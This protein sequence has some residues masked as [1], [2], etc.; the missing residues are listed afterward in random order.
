MQVYFSNVDCEAI[1]PRIALQIAYFHDYECICGKK[2]RTY[3]L[4]SLV[5]SDLLKQ[6][7]K[8]AYTTLFRLGHPFHTA[9]KI[10]SL[11]FWSEVKPNAILFVYLFFLSF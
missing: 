10:A 11:S 2:E 3:E 8:P 4:F 5:L 6:K 7:N 1:W 9:S